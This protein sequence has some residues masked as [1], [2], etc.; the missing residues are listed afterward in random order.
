M[1]S[2]GIA[3]VA[4]EHLLMLPG[5]LCGPA[6]WCAQQ[7]QLSQ[8]AAV[9]HVPLTVDPLDAQVDALLATAPPRFALLG[10]SLGG[11]VAM[12]VARRAPD[13][14]TRLALLSTNPRPPTDAQRVAWAQCRERVLAGATPRQ[15]Q[16]RLLPLLLHERALREQPVTVATVL[17]MA[18]RISVDELLAQLRLQE[19]RVDERPGLTRLR[20]PT[21]VVAA[22][23]DGLVGM[24]PH[25]EI[26]S[27]VPGAVLEVVPDSGHL[28]PLEAPAKVTHLLLR[29]WEA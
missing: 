25:E 28:A 2:G 5:M 9:R 14:V 17:G 10:L 13:R 19:S 27:A 1:S 16:E 21:L 22:A 29:W 7:E 12:A 6:L 20:C 15:E 3:P 24:A 18:E 4:R 23:G 8:R 11:I 26:A